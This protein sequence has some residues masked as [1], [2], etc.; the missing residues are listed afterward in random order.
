[1]A[2]SSLRSAAPPPAAPALGAVRVGGH[3]LHVAGAGHGDDQLV[4]GD[5]VLERHLAVVGD[6]H[7]TPGIGELLPDL[8][9]LLLDDLPPL[10]R[11]GED[12]LQLGDEILELG[13]LGSQLVDFQGGEA[14][15][16]HV[17]DG[18]RL[19]LGQLEPLHEG[20]AGSPGVGRPADDADHLVDVVDGDDHLE[21]VGSLLG[22]VEA[23]PGP[24]L[25]DLHLVVEVVAD[26][27]GHVERARHPVD[28]GDHVV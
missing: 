18:V 23:E 17:E 14:P 8:A 4:V 19:D 20:G 2:S 26:H 3:R 12:R 7:R 5:E 24:P 11:V 15:Q 1:M 25:D 21:D 10:H 13:E 6:D 28:Q 27:L 22:L 9:H 16:G